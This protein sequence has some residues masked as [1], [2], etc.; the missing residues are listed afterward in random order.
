MDFAIADGEVAQRA[1]GERQQRL[2][3]KKSGSKMLFNAFAET[4]WSVESKTDSTAII[5]V[6]GDAY[7][8][9]IK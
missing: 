3:G 8:Y 6:Q 7:T 4:T 5:I 2:G 1:I 9:E